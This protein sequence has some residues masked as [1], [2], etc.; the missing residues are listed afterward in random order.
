M[1]GRVLTE[2]LVGVDVDHSMGEAAYRSH[3]A[4]RGEYR[5]VL[6]TV[7][8]AGVSYVEQANRV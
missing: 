5:Q 8:Y 2:G 3:E 7:D 6:Q 4:T 1:D